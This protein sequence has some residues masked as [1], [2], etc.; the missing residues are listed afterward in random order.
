VPGRRLVADIKLASVLA[1]G[2]VAN[3]RQNA[4]EGAVRKAPSQ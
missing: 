2:T 1:F 4:N 3:E